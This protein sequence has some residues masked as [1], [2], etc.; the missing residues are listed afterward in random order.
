MSGQELTDGLW[1]DFDGPGTAEEASEGG[2]DAEPAAG[3]SAPG[4]VSP[5]R[6]ASLSPRPGAAR[7]RRPARLPFPAPF[8]PPSEEAPRVFLDLGR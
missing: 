2:R 4:S 7:A 5:P 6:P 3:Q 8:L 1:L